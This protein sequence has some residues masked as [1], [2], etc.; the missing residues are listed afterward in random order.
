MVETER[1][2]RKTEGGQQRKRQDRVCLRFTEVDGGERP[3]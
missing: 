2:G 1:G 3:K